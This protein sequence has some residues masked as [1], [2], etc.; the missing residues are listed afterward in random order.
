MNAPFVV[1]VQSNVRG[2]QT[3]RSLGQVNDRQKAA[4]RVVKAKLRR[5]KPRRPPPSRKKALQAIPS[6]LPTPCDFSVTQ[7]SISA[8]LLSRLRI[9]TLARL[10]LRTEICAYEREN[11]KPERGK[12]GPTAGLF[13]FS[14]PELQQSVGG[15]QATKGPTNSRARSNEKEEAPTGGRGLLRFLGGTL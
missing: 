10:T 8:C 7:R 3:M 5:I 14:A 6:P 13:T 1:E 15:L 9:A 4:G 12:P 2:V 11:R